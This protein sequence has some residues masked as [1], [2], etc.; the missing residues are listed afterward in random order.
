MCGARARE[1]TQLL[2]LLKDRYFAPSTGAESNLPPP[3][4]PIAWYPDELGWRMNASRF[5][6]R[7]GKS[8]IDFRKFL[9][10]QTELVRARPAPHVREGAVCVG[11]PCSAA[12]P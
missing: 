11:S 6:M 7:R 4:V 5:E 8:L 9:V 10:M 3:A 1:A 2:Q 12:P